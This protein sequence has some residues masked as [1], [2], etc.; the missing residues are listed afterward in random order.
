MKKVISKFLVVFFSLIVLFLSLVGAVCTCVEAGGEH[1]FYISDKPWMHCVL[2]LTVL[3][4]GILL[5]QKKNIFNIKYGE[6]V[7]LCALFVFTAVLAFVVIKLA[8]APIADQRKVLLVVQHMLE[9]DYKDF[10][11]GGYLAEYSNQSGIVY[12]YYLIYRYLGLGLN[13]IRVLNVLSYIGSIV[14]MAKIGGEICGKQYTIITGMVY[15][16]FL[17]M[18]FYIPFIYGNLLGFFFSLVAVYYTLKYMNEASWKKAVIIIIACVCAN[19]VKQNF[20]ITVIAV[21][22]ILCLHAIFEKRAKT[23]LVIL[24]IG[25][26]VF[27][28]SFLV[29]Y[30]LECISGEKMNNAM[31]ATAWIAMGMQYGDIANGW[32]NGYNENI[33]EENN[34]DR[35]KTN[36]VAKKEIRERVENF[37]KHPGQM[38]D[39]YL[40]KEVS[41]WNESCFEAY[42]INYL[43]A[44][45]NYN[46]TEVKNYSTFKKSFISPGNITMKKYFNYYYTLLLLGVVAWI[47][48]EKDKLN[49]KRLLLCIT[50]IGGF[51][52]HTF[53]EGKSQYTLTYFALFVPYAVGGYAKLIQE[54]YSAIKEMK[55]N[56]KKGTLLKYKSVKYVLIVCVC[57]L[58]LSCVEHFIAKTS[59][60]CDTNY[61]LNLIKK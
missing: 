22:L 16:A 3:C 39:F 59:L 43:D 50:I 33:Y 8:I 40:R 2:F 10:R 5:Y 18:M 41:Q 13:F 7:C 17:P 6:K 37:L 56:K 27:S 11:K 60:A 23:I 25:I 53:W 9:G 45:E 14:V 28:V 51:V 52:F 42:W 49:Y 46:E 15:V 20:I 44:R 47:V 36:E 19:Q 26:S 48:M 21:A 4:F 55:L 57:L 32:Y 12:F 1:V 38:I 61:Y 29:N 58:A 54:L 34:Y 31:P 24:L 30:R 35:N